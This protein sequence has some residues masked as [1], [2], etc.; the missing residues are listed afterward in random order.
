[1]CF[2]LCLPLLQGTWPSA[3]SDPVPLPVRFP[4]LTSDRGLPSCSPQHGGCTHA[5]P[6]TEATSLLRKA[7]VYELGGV[8]RVRN[9]KYLKEQQ[10]YCAPSCSDSPSCAGH[11]LISP[12]D[13]TGICFPFPHLLTA[14]HG[15]L[16][17]AL[18]Q[19][20]CCKPQGPQLPEGGVL[21]TQ[22]RMN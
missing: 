12:E 5:R 15:E 14:Q 2:A 13:L 17:L 8:K 7:R 9:L 10:S 6:F 22:G 4:L 18:A 3:S 21:C 16:L 1:M 19:Q 11:K 20:L